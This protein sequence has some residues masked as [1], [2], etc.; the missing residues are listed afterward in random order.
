MPDWTQHVRPRLSGLR[1]SPTREAEIIEELSQHLDDRY[2]ELLAGGMS[3]A[4]ATREALSDFREGDVLAH[5]LAPLRQAR[6]PSAITPG[7]TRSNFLSDLWRD[8]RYAMRMIRKN[9]GFACVV[10]ITLALG[11]GANSAIFSFINAVIL[12]PLPFHD[13]SRLVVIDEIS[14]QG[15]EM[16]VSLPDLTDWRAQA[17]S[18]EEIAGVNNISFNLVGEGTPQRLNGQLVTANLFH[19]LGVQPQL[20]RTFTAEEDKYGVPSTALISDSL[21]RQAFGSDPNII[22][23]HIDLGDADVVTVIGVMPP[24]FEII[25]KSDVWMPL[26]L[27]LSPRS[28]WLDRG[29]HMGLRA[30]GRLKPGIPLEQSVTEIRLIQAQLDR[31]YPVVNA[32]ISVFIGTLQSRL[33]R[34]IRPTL[35][36]LMGAVGFVLLIACVNVANLSLARAAVRQ[37]EMGIRMALGAPRHRLIRQLLTESLL[38]GL[39]GGVVGVL[40]GRWLLSGLIA[41]SPEDMPRLAD[42]QMNGRV[43]LF[44]TS[45]T[46]LTSFLFGL[47]PTLPAT[48]NSLSSVFNKTGRSFT[49]GPLRR[50]IFDALLVTEIAFALVLL[51]GSGLMAR[52]MYKVYQV[53][54]GF[55]TDHLLTMR[56]TLMDPKYHDPAQCVVFE[57]DAIAKVEAVPG[58]ESASFTLS[59]PNQGSEWG[60]VFV[61]ENQPVPERD[62]VPSAAINPA[63]PEYFKTMGIP[64]LQGRLFTP[65]D[66]VETPKV[67]IVNETL[68]RRFWPNQN[69]IGK[70]LRQGWPESPIDWREVVGVVGDIKLDGVLQKTPSHIYLPL[71][72]SHPSDLFLAVRTQ[73]DPAPMTASIQ[74]ALHTVDPALPFYDI[75]TMDELAK[76]A[77]MPQ[78]AATILLSIFAVVAILLAAVGIYGVISWGVVKRT[79]EMGLRMAL[80]AMR[81]DVVWLVLRRSMLLVLLG[82]GLGLVGA[83]ALTR[84]L[85]SMISEG[86]PGKT[87]L[88]FGVNAVDPFTFIAVPLLLSLVA[89]LACVVPALRATKIDP[90]KALRYE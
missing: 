41:L 13:P 78:R 2:R 47:L 31:E 53:D 65:S 76:R 26:S 20:G 18:F 80:G 71:A 39:F 58:V 5:Y 60:S 42:V 49:D 63:G 75:R 44:T 8:I 86:G 82:V 10:V 21:W 73:S 55:R 90:L 57:R 43:L 88:L 46:L 67:V 61:V 14:S 33:V 54:P 56:M 27:W 1:L 36:V 37:P 38:L 25:K 22:G 4:E 19:V 34:E 84:V 74:A 50:R 23:R 9:P 15:E 66:T 48:R 45:L 40:V 24:R 29:N 28:A 7:T 68:A 87:P 83:Y 72:Q 89:F 59:L 62:K 51:T 32:G 17:Q 81:R 3:A 30:I 64:L 6:T 77:T 69:P 85:S 79:R 16:S 70:R 35:L 52:T 12:S 11:I